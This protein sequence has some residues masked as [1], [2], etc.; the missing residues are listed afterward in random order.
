M[1][2]SMWCGAAL[3][4]VAMAA[5]PARADAPLFAEEGEIA[6]TL[7]AQFGKLERAAKRSVDPVPAT[8]TLPGGA[9]DYALQIAPRGFSR[10]TGEICSFPPLKLDLDKKAMEGTLFDDQNKLKLVTQCRPQSSYEQLLLREYTVYRLY[11]QLSPLSFR[12]RLARVTY[13]DTD[14]RGPGATQ[15]GFLI[16]DA[17]AMAKRN[18]L[19]EIEAQPRQLTAGQLDPQRAALFAMFE[20]VIGNLDWEYFAGPPGDFCCHNA[21]LAGPKDATSGILP[22]PY[23]FDF[24]ALVDAPYATPPEGLNVRDAHVRY[25]RGH[26]RF[27]AQAPG[28]LALLQ[29]K[30]PAFAAI[31][32]G[33]TRISEANRREMQAY[34]DESFEILADPRRFEREIIGRC[35]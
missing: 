6:F 10:R 18:G 1:W 14:G 22:T 23:D 20:F 16:E 27:N 32:A 29:E 28:A 11:N 2:K 7:H 15:Y 19:V 3:L 26:C 8:L 4:A 31:I 25:Y 30:R 21:K 9:Q 34:L 13:H 35:R 33:E 24:S 5:T 12:V 17:D